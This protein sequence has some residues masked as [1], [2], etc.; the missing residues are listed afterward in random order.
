MNTKAYLLNKLDT[1]ISYEK[2]RKYRIS[3]HIEILQNIY[4]VLE[5]NYIIE[6]IKIL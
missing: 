2:F 3:I 1:L 4:N 6:L 5:E